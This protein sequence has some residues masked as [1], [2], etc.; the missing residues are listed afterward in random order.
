M[1]KPY[2][3]SGTSSERGGEL[4]KEMQWTVEVSG[5]GTCRVTWEPKGAPG[6]VSEKRMAEGDREN[7]SDKGRVCMKAWRKALWR[8][9]YLW[10]K[11]SS[12]GW[13]PGG[14]R[15]EEGGG[16]SCGL[17]QAKGEGVWPLP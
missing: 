1:L 7:V 8:M 12:V 9:M 14:E 16:V 2:Y 3:D 13:S 11:R 4:S 17:R 6:H 5:W 15:M 10:T